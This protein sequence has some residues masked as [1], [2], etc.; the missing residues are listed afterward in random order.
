MKRFI[1]VA[2]VAVLVVAGVAVSVSVGGGSPSDGQSSYLQLTPGD[3]GFAEFPN[4]FVDFAI[5]W[6]GEEF[7]GHK[8]RHIIRNEFSGEN[9]L[10]PENGVSFLYGTCEIV[11]EGGCP[12][13]I[14]IITE[15]RC[16][17]PPE[18]VGNGVRPVG[19]ETVRG[20]A[21]AIEVGGGTRLWTGDVTVKVYTA[22]GLMEATIAALTSPNGLG[23]SAGEDMPPPVDD[24]PPYHTPDVSELN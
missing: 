1:P 7:A 23:V 3:E 2:I 20:D 12:P 8:L 19:I 4:E 16:F 9:V 6:V 15:P 24:C 5:Y 18:L 10:R 22:P 13:P 17:V 11:G 14:Q 21:D